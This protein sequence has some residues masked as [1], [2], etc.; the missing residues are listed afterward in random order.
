MLATTVYPY[1]VRFLIN[2]L[3]RYAEHHEE[4]NSPHWHALA[5]AAACLERMLQGETPTDAAE[6][7]RRLESLN[8]IDPS[9]MRC[10]KAYFHIVSLAEAMIEGHRLGLLVIQREALRYPRQP[11]WIGIDIGAGDRT[12]F[13]GRHHA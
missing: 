7:S 11:L 12:A 1:Q 4:E 6:V 3:T 13:G 2:G 9:P 8:L 10:G 5:S